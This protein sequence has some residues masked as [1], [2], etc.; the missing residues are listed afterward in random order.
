MNP[1]ALNGQKCTLYSSRFYY[2]KPS[3]YKDKSKEK[4]NARLI[5]LT[6]LEGDGRRTHP[7]IAT[8]RKSKYSHVVRFARRQVTYHSFQRI[9]DRYNRIISGAHIVID[10]PNAYLKKFA[11]PHKSKNV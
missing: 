1:A 5:K 11:L 3:T 6:H 2:Q 9:A 7:P 8:V 10:F 4:C